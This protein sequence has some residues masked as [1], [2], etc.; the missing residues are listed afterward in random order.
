MQFRRAASLVVRAQDVPGRMLGVGAFS[1]M[2]RAREY[3]NQRLR[4]GK[5][6][7]LSFHCRSGSSIRASKRRFCSSR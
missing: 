2:S 7:G 5:S 6:I 1:I 3:S 4:D